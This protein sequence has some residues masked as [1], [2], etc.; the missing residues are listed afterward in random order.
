MK[1]KIAIV[2]LVSGILVSFG[3]TKRSKT[4]QSDKTELQATNR[5]TGVVGGFVSEDR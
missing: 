2:L 1:T 4:Q 3:A 5:S